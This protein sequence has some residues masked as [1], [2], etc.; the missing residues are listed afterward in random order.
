MKS[1]EVGEDFY[2]ADCAYYPQVK[3]HIFMHSRVCNS[4]MFC[5]LYFL[6][7]FVGVRVGGCIIN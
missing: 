1:W 2:G 3:V 6:Y 7:F 5:I 4:A